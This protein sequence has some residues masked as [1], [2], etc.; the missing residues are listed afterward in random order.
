MDVIFTSMEMWHDIYPK[1]KHKVH[2]WCITNESLQIQ[3]ENANGA[4]T[5]LL[6]KDLVHLV[7][8]YES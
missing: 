6:I 1:E 2:T 8:C 7:E 4:K 5:T 3:L